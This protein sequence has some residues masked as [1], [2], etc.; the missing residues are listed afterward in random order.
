[1]VDRDPS[2]SFPDNL[3][4]EMCTDVEILQS[5]RDRVMFDPSFINQETDQLLRANPNLATFIPS[6]AN[7]LDQLIR[8]GTSIRDAL[9]IMG[10]MV[11]ASYNIQSRIQQVESSTDLPVETVTNP[12]KNSKIGK[13]FIRITGGKLISKMKSESRTRNKLSLPSA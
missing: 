7:A 12:E 3:S 8:E 5:I 4:T 2:N 11:G 6:Y 13:H 9:I 10:L 1:M